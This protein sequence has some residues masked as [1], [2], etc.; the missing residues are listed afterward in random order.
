MVD[1]SKG[2][3]Q[4]IKLSNLMLD[5]EN[6]RL[7][8]LVEG[9][10]W[11]QPRILLAFAKQDHVRTLAQHI[12]HHGTNPIK[13][14]MVLEHPERAGG[15]IVLEGNRRLAALR[16]LRSPGLAGPSK[17]FFSDLA[18]TS[19]K[20]PSSLN[21]VVVSTREEA[22]VWIELEHGGENKGAGVWKWD[23]KEATRF[24]V[25]RGA[26][27]ARHAESL[28]LLEKLQE[29]K[30]I[31]V[32]TMI[33]VPIT[34]LD[35]VIRDPHIRDL[36]SLDLSDPEFE[37]ADVDTLTRLVYDLASKRV[38]VSDVFSK[39][40]RAKFFSDY[41]AEKNKPEAPG[42]AGAERRKKGI[43][44]EAKSPAKRSLN[45]KRQVLI[46]SD[47]INKSTLPR[48]KK[49]VKELKSLKVRDFPNATAVS[50][51]ALFD[52]AVVTY[53]DFHKI[54]V[55]S[56]DS[57]PPGIKAIAE[58]ILNHLESSSDAK[59]RKALHPVRTAL[60]NKNSIFSVETLHGYVH[61]P[62]ANPLP[63]D[64]MAQFDSFRP[65]FDKVLGE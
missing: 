54:I 7:P 35:R 58:A 50:F 12:A 49:L 52:I 23:P 10:T 4:L 3:L 1:K 44:K 31:D 13:R 27:A 40:D 18:K 65:F 48:L 24:K 46:P 56:K 2:E 22:N 42:D 63:D 14:L 33:G 28:R 19:K 57:R 6:P 25:R 61:D 9:E 26:G 15:F 59:G 45:V 37:G 20:L 43:A 51:R 5:E 38:K 53:A 16:L 11:S 17:K 32:D 29:A 8:P 64:L 36:F 34:T 47:F 41:F 55:P 60:S 62:H 21:C 39:D 30:R